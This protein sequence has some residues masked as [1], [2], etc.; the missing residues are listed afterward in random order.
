MKSIFYSFIK[1]TAFNIDKFE[2]YVIMFS[3][4]FACDTVWHKSCTQLV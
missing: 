2:K 3:V 4:A 1:K